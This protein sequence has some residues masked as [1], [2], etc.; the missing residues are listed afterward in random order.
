MIIDDGDVD[1]IDGGD[2]DGGGGDVDGRNPPGTCTPQNHF[3]INGI[4]SCH[5][6]KVFDVMIGISVPVGQNYQNLVI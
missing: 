4:K 6:K 2:V 5:V 3:V 1:G